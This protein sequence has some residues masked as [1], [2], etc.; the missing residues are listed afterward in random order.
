MSMSAENIMI[1]NTSLKTSFD[2]VF[3]FL[4]DREQDTLLLEMKGD[5]NELIRLI[6]RN[7]KTNSKIMRGKSSEQ[8]NHQVL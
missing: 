6:A 1:N 2:D 3:M 4:I 8:L 5:L 7:T